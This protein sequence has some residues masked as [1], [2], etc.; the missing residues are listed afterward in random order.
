MGDWLISRTDLVFVGF[1][2]PLEAN[3]ARRVLT[4]LAKALRGCCECFEYVA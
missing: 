1:V 2:S 3:R 4:V